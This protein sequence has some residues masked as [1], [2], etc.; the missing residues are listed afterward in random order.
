M[1]LQKP[2]EE[3][4]ATK[5][6]EQLLRIFA[7][8]APNVTIVKY[9]FKTD[10]FEPITLSAKEVFELW[11]KGQTPDGF[12]DDRYIADESKK[13]ARQLFEKMKNAVP[14]GFAYIKLNDL[15]QGWRWQ[16]FKYSTVFDKDRNPEYSVLSYEDVTEKHERELALIRLSNHRKLNKAFLM[17]E[18]NL[19]L[20]T[21]EGSEG[22]LTEG[23]APYFPLSYTEA[24]KRIS[25]DV[26]PPYDEVFRRVFP[27]E[28]LLEA[29]KKGLNYDTEEIF[30]NYE[31][32][33]G[34]VRVFYQ[35]L[36]DP[37]SS[38]VLLNV[39]LMDIDEEKENELKLREMATTDRLTGISNRAAFMDHVNEKCLIRT[40]G[41]NRALIMLD[42]DGFS[43][44]ND[45]F[46]HVYGDDMLKNVAHTLKISACNESIVARL[47][48]DVF[49]VFA[50]GYENSEELRERL[51]MMLAAVHRELKLGMKLSV[52]AGVAIYP[53]DG[54]DFDSLYKKADLALY[55]AKLTGR[56]K[57]TIYED[58]MQ[59]T[60]TIFKVADNLE[61]MLPNVGIY[62][63]TF[64]YFEVFLNGK[65]ILIKNAKA[66]ELLAFLVG[67]QGAY[68]SQADIISCLWEDEPVNKL[69]LG[70]LR[71]TVMILKDTLKDY[72][73]EELIESK[74]GM[75]RLNTSIVNCD[76]YNYLSGK[77][78]YVNL[79]NGA[80]MLN[81]SWGDLMLH[82]LEA[83]R[84]NPLQRW[85]Y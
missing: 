59:N 34:W 24:F 25:E 6:R 40:E 33:P 3:L 71:K 48:G 37:Y 27:R 62:I 63:K 73:I 4:D 12:F 21:F 67:R 18:Y 69:T 55:H 26:L 16:A 41:L 42:I 43:K 65:A 17:V 9:D 29:F 35:L 61:P 78:E 45:V 20:D 47:G 58:G 60:K 13:E 82:E 68:A 66:K 46:G 80:Y 14:K 22:E 10:R 81:Y 77:S 54:K 31:G 51:R 1:E 84:K 85:T 56:N 44:I 53:R 38:S 70:R 32:V 57:Y 15:R 2:Q 49:A 5:D 75:R 36:K 76:L 23:Y 7:E 52:S 28:R 83:L 72:G 74:S 39:L 11:P 19:S 8:S 64:G 50:M 79:F 30:I